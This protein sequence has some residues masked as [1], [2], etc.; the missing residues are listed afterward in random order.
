MATVEINSF[1]GK[2][3]NL[4]KSGLDASLRLESHAGQASVSLHL[5]LGTWT[6]EAEKPPVLKKVSPSRTRR[7]H[8]Q[9]KARQDAADCVDNNVVKVTSEEDVSECV[10]ETTEMVP[11]EEVASGVNAASDYVR[12]TD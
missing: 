5:G 6:E 12:L 4:W 9:A 3:L 10:K 2:F 1:I 7:R 11:S 8:R